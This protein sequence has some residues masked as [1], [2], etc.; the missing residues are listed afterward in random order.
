MQ[1][2]HPSISNNWNFINNI[3]YV[4]T[5][6]FDYNDGDIEEQYIKK[7]IETAVDISSNSNE[8]EQHIKDWPS[9]YH[10]SISRANCYRSLL[11]SKNSN[12]LELGSGCGAITRYLGENCGKVTAVEGSP[13]RALITRSRT[14]DLKN[15]DVICGSFGALN[16]NTKFDYVICNGVL[17]YA[18]LFIKGDDPVRAF[19]DAQKNLLSDNGSLIIAIENKLGLRYFS[20]GKEEHTGAMFDGLED[21]NRFP[22]GPQTFSRKELKDLLKEKFSDVDIFIPLPDY[23]F[24]KALIKEE[25]FNKVDCSELISSLSEYDYSSAIKPKMY[26]RLVWKSLNKARVINDFSN[27]FFII[28]G[29]QTESLTSKDWLGSIFS[30][31][32]KRA[33]WRKTDIGLGP[34]G[35]VSTI[36]LPFGTVTENPKNTDK[37]S[38]T[39]S[40]EWLTG[41]SIHTKIVQSFLIKGALESNKV[42][43][44]AI[45]LW[46]HAVK[47]EM[48]FEKKMPPDMIDAV[49]QNVIT[50]EEEAKVFDREWKLH[51]EVMPITLIYRSVICF[52]ANEVRFVHRWSQSPKNYSQMR[53]IKLI[54]KI[55]G[56]TVSIR[57]V[58]G[59]VSDDKTFVDFTRGKKVNIFWNLVRLYLPISLLHLKLYLFL[60][61]RVFFSRVKKKIYSYMK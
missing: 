58:L 61:Q 26:E 8:L 45:R 4:G 32:R 31:D 42:F 23:K 53:L 1:P 15:V 54:A 11:F 39:V 49:W 55:T 29:N 6:N 22:K 36:K 27:S 52:V 25:L 43:D 14:R 57:S 16:F 47:A 37:I 46:W 12:V 20:S 24:P 19:I 7:T 21:Y 51:K 40:Q 9:R 17:E 13:R 30:L 56:N 35:K 28:A 41:P 34:N 48:D 3:Y 5:E 10:L 2:I 18:P 33:S 44:R 60:N 59:A 38:E 50:N